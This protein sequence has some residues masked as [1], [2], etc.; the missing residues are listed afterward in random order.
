ME[1]AIQHRPGLTRRVPCT[2]A[3]GAR[4]RHK[5]RPSKSIECLEPRALLSADFTITDLGALGPG[6]DARPESINDSGQVALTID[7]GTQ[8]ISGAEIYQTSL[9]TPGTGLKGLGK[10]PQTID[11]EATAINNSGTVVGWCDT[12]TVDGDGYELYRAFEYTPQ[13]GM[14]NLGLPS[15]D[16]SAK[17]LG[18]NNSSEVVGFALDS[19]DAEIPILGM[20]GSQLT[21]F[22]DTGGEAEGINDLGQITG[23]LENPGIIQTQAFVYVPGKR[24]TILPYVPGSSDR[25]GDGYKINDSGVIVG[26]AQSADGF[27]HTPFYYSPSTGTLDLGALLSAQT[28]DDVNNAGVVVGSLQGGDAMVYT[29]S[30]GAVDL[31]S[32]IPAGSGWT[33]TEATCINNEDD[34]CGIGTAPDGATHAFLLTPAA[35]LNLPQLSFQAQPGTTSAGSDL[36]PAVTVAVENAL[37]GVLPSDNSTVTLTLNG[38]GALSGTTSAAAVNGIA[39]FGNLSVSA[40]GQFTLTAADGTDTPAVS[41]T[42]TINPPASVASSVTLQTSNVSPS[43]GEMV[44]LTATVTGSDGGTPTGTVTFLNGATALGSAELD[45]N[46]NASLATSLPAGSDSVLSD[47]SGD[48]TYEPSESNTITET[49]SPTAP[50]LVPTLGRAVIPASAIAGMPIAA[51]LAVT[52]TNSGAPLRGAVTINVFADSGTTLD[53]NQHLLS[54]QTRNVSLRSAQHTAFNLSVKTLPASLPPGNYYFIIQVLGPSGGNATTASAATFDVSAPLVRL[55]ATVGPV[56][57]AEIPVNRSAVLDVSVTNSGNIDSVGPLDLTVNA[58]TDGQS[59][60]STI[61][62]E[63]AKTVR[64]RSGRTVRFILRIRWNSQLSGMG[65]YYPFI[66]LSQGGQTA[67]AAG[68]SP[69]SMA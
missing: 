8:T 2:A 14:I 49:V 15:G 46:G 65:N 21:P 24:S 17:A 69:F 45:E 55:S 50:Q 25:G 20:S 39:T 32:L 67:T 66:T 33:L 4:R 37:G 56:V 36:S 42:F 62:G 58:S 22:T 5:G 64:I 3:Q 11:S 35:A 53:A 63:L 12:G 40:A 26:S 43:A 68:T 7:T 61:L 57:P 18:I 59:A 38:S 28:A 27:S 1:Q 60:D 29:A 23:T 54:T 41:S 30:G 13:G 47:Y 31:N 10:L 44:V 52:A 19:G 34:I 51:H 6:P 16:I 9:Y 48:P